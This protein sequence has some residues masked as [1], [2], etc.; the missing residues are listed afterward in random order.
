MQ[1][2]LIVD[3][4]PKVCECLR[5]FFS[6]KGYAARCAYTGEQALE[7]L[8]EDQPDIVLL[9]IGLPGLSGLEVL[10]RSRDLCP[11][12]HVIMVSGYTDGETEETARAH[13]AKAYITK[14]FDFSDLTWAPVFSQN[15]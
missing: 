4:E 15:A 6:A 11:H 8:L 13:G 1:R 10:K 12:A 7:S 3:D 5:L 9:D 14:P 2:L